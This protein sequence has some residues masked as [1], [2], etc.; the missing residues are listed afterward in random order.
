MIGVPG[1]DPATGARTYPTP[2][3][4][5]ELLERRGFVADQPAAKVKGSVHFEEYW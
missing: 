5:I 1:K 4:V 3:G 2:V